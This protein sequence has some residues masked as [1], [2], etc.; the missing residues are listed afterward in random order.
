MPSRDHVLGCRTSADARE[1]DD[2]RRPFPV[3]IP[4]RIRQWMEAEIEQRM[5]RCKSAGQVTVALQN[6]TAADR[7]GV[8]RMTGFPS[9]TD[10]QWHHWPAFMAPI[11]LADD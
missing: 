5:A 4:V 2:Y 8:L 3:G 9:G 11:A 1:C 7:A 10:A 6:L